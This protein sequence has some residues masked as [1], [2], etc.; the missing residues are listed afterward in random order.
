MRF[1][2]MIQQA[3][4]DGFYRYP[5]GTMAPLTREDMGLYLVAAIDSVALY[6]GTTFSRAESVLY[7]SVIPRPRSDRRICS[8][9]P[10]G[11]QIRLPK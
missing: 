8:L 6:Q 9:L 10:F 4:I 5:D 11:E 7:R 1:F 2:P 3:A